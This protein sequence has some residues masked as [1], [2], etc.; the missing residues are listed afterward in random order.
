M[1][2]QISDGHDE[3]E[4]KAQVEA[5]LQV[6]WDVKED[7]KLE[8]TYNFKTYTKVAVRNTLS[9]LTMALTV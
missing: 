7:R 4:T 3:A 8:K 9:T 6:G 1:P 2:L 5:L